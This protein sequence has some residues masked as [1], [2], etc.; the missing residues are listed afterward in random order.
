[1]SEVFSTRRPMID[2]DEF[3]RRLCPPCSTDQKDGDPLAEL[4]RIIGGKD[5]SQK[6]KRAS[7]P[8]QRRFRCNRGR[9]A[10]RT[11]RTSHGD[12]FRNRH[13]KCFFERGH[14]IATFPPSG[15]PA[16]FPTRR[17]HR[18]AKQITAPALCHGCDRHRGNGRHSRRYWP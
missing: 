2:L 5:E 13:V 14:R 4:L 8:H 12:G 7:A 17:R 3:E 1:M 9:I 11:A 10:G 16:G 18:R 15:Q 6:A